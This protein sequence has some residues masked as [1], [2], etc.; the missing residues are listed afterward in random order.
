MLLMQEREENL[1][2]KEVEQPDP[3]LAFHTSANLSHLVPVL[4]QPIGQ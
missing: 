2:S 4:I 3:N 1:Q